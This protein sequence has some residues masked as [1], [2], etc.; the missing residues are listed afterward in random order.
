[1]LFLFQ[2][3]RSIRTYNEETEK[4]RNE[5]NELRTKYDSSFSSFI[6]IIITLTKRLLFSHSS[7]FI[8]QCQDFPAEQ[9]Y[10]VPVPT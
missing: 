6:F 1:M 9:V 4:M 3:L 10:S 2:D 7:S 8:I 5:I